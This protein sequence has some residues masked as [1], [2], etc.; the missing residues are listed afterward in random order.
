MRFDLGPLHAPITT[1]TACWA[2]TIERQKRAR[3]RA[4]YDRTRAELL[5]GGT[6]RSRA[7]IVG[8]SINNPHG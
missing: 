5:T 6:R 1:P 8:R 3:A 7:V 4:H 2:D